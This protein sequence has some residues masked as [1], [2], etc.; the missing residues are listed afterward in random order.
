MFKNSSRSWTTI[1][2]MFVLAQFFF[3]R[4]TKAVCYVHWTLVLCISVVR[5]SNRFTAAAFVGEWNGSYIKVCA[6]N[7]LLF[8]HLVVALT[9]D[10]NYPLTQIFVPPEYLIPPQPKMILLVKTVFCGAFFWSSSVA[11]GLEW[12]PLGK[13]LGGGDQLEGGDHPPEGHH[14]GD[15]HPEARAARAQQEADP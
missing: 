12:V 7:L 3:F 6:A 13:S 11:G 15:H 8:D 9:K 14:Q 4:T 10:H 2:L 1:A 5:K